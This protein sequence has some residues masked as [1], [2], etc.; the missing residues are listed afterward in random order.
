MGPKGPFSAEIIRA[1]RLFNLDSRALTVIS[2]LDI[3]DN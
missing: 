2:T 1:K 3:T